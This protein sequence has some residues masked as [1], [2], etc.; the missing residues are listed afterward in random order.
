MKFGICIDV[1]N[2]DRAVTF[3][4]RGIGLRVVKQGPDWGELELDG[5]SLYIMQLPR[6]A[7][8]YIDPRLV[9]D[10][11]RHWTPVHLDF[12]VDDLET[13]VKRALEAGA[14]LDRPIQHRD[15]LPNM[16]NMADPFGN[17]FDLIQRKS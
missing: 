9:R 11:G 16:A 15:A 8:P 13:A 2:A 3:Y 1:E 7:D 14:T 4:S 12:M 6:G 5:Q 10:Y 17:G